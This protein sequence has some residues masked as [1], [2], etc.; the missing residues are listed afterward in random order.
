M[1]NW[2]FKSKLQRAEE[3]ER[4]VICEECVEKPAS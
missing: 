3:E 2:S 4:A 1:I